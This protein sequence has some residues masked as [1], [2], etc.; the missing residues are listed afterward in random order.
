MSAI[1][2]RAGLERLAQD[3]CGHNSRSFGDFLVKYELDI[4]VPRVAT[5]LLASIYD[6]LVEDREGWLEDVA[7]LIGSQ[8]AEPDV[9]TRVKCDL[10]FGRVEYAGSSSGVSMHDRIVAFMDLQSFVDA[11]E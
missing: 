10:L 9:G 5:W 4:P 11:G 3:L 7:N 2:P 8:L 6:A 1:T